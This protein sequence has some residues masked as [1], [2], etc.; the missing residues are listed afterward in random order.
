MLKHSDCYYCIPGGYLF[1]NYT[2]EDHAVSTRMVIEQRHE[3]WPGIPHGGVGMAAF[4]ELCDM[5]DEGKTGFP[6]IYTFRFGGEQIAVGDVVELKVTGSEPGYM[7]EMATPGTGMPYLKA[8]MRNG[9]LDNWDHVQSRA[10]S[11]RVSMRYAQHTLRIPDMSYRLLFKNA[12]KHRRDM[13]TFSFHEYS[14]GHTMLYCRSRDMAGKEGRSFNTLHGDHIHPG[15]L[16][17]LLDETMGWAGFLSAW[18]GGVTV[19][20]D[21]NLFKPVC[22]TDSFVVCGMC[23]SIAGSAQRKLVHV[24]GAVFTEKDNGLELSGYARG[25]WLT[26]PGYKEK[27]VQYLLGSENTEGFTSRFPGLI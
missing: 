21:V 1:N 15:V 17:T 22:D 7:G 8:L 13:R 5:L 18:Q 9:M 11:M 10:S 25:R 4:V 6:L 12:S 24:T 14:K 3:G 19:I 20:L 16:I 26:L 2:V 23:N 27:M